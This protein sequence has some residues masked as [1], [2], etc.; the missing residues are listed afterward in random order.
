MSSLCSV[1]ST[2][3]S[4]DSP[5]KY[6]QEDTK[7]F[8]YWDPFRADVSTKCIWFPLHESRKSLEQGLDFGCEICR[9]I[10]SKT[11]SDASDLRIS[12]LFSPEKS[13]PHDFWIVESSDST[14]LPIKEENALHFHIWPVDTSPETARLHQSAVLASKSNHTGSSGW[15]EL[16][17]R[18][19]VECTTHHRHCSRLS[20]PTWY[21]KRLLPI[22]GD[23]INLVTTAEHEMHGP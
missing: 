1:C 16:A 17:S 15:L 22:V 14:G 8:R 20:A 13:P 11:S 5:E 3:F 18:W 10:K 19:L 23:K 7:D 4:D 2:I 21:P 9:C 12:F 6:G